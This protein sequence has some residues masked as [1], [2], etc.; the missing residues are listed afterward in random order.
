MSDHHHKHNSHTEHHE[1][2]ILPDSTAIKVGAALLGLTVITVA[3][4]FVHLGPLNFLVGMLVAIIKASLVA[5]V[6][7]NLSKDHK[8]NT[9]IFAT[10]FVFLVIFFVLTAT[11]L[12]FREK[13][14][15]TDNKSIFVEAAGGPAKFRKAWL[16]TDELKVHGKDV[17]AAQC[18]TCHGAEGKGDGA[19]AGAL[20]PK[21]RN[22][23]SADNWKNGRKPTQIFKTL[24]EGIPGGA[25]GSFSTLSVDDR[26]ALVHY[27]TSLGPDQLKD[28]ANDYKLAGIDPNADFM[29]G[30]E[31]KSIHIDDAIELLSEKGPSI[32]SSANDSVVSYGARLKEKTLSK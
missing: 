20:N 16:P 18:A 12:L 19:A 31:K 22:F 21:P 30:G 7:M 10:G 11:D 15:Y 6:F 29:G 4:S 24:K 28:D 23:H 32:N 13:G 5:A 26:W 27:V 1:H 17:F 2:Y 14:I 25:M 3:L 8:S 9:V